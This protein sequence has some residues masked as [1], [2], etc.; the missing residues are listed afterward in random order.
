MSRTRF[1]RCAI[2]LPLAFC[3]GCGVEAD[4]HR[5]LEHDTTSGKFSLAMLGSSEQLLREGRIDEHR[6][7]R[8]ED[9]VEIDVWRIGSRSQDAPPK[10]TAVILHG[11]LASKAQN[12]R[13][14]EALARAGYDVVLLDH[15]AHGQSGGRYITWGAKE[16]RDAKTVVDAL[17]ADK[18][19]HEPVYVWGISMGAATAILY[20]ALDPRCKGVFA[21]APYRDGR[22]ISRRLLPFVVVADYQAAWK[23]AG[24]IAGFDPAQTDVL[25]AVRTLHCPLIIVH[26]TFDTIVP[27]E[28]GKALYAA[29][30][31]PKKFIS[32][33]FGNHLTVLLMNSDW[34]VE[35]V[36]WLTTMSEGTS[37]PAK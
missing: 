6:R 2:L 3:A 5:L 12:F 30:P 29:A 37:R 1:Y 31:Q 22:E 4:A 18:E 24:E 26:G 17:L 23:R 20:G 25:A 34:Y 35:R 21:V 15:R 28:N 8:A 14:G 27:Y 32:V 19:I 13:L 7:V 9:G 33:P 11:V 16:A 36:G 10:G